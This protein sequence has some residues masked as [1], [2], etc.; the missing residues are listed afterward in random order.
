[1]GMNAKYAAL[2]AVILLIALG[3]RVGAAWWWQQRIGEETEFGFPDSDSYWVLAQTIARGQPYRYGDAD[4]FRTPAYP[5]ALAGLFWAYG[6]QPPVMAARLLGAGLGTLTVGVVACLAGMLFDR[7]AA[8]AAATMA[9]LYP[10]AIAMSTLV[11]SEALFCPLMVTQLLL[12]TAAWRSKSTGRFLVLSAAAGIVAGLAVLT[13]PSWLLFTPFAIVVAMCFGPRRLRQLGLGAVM[14]TTFALAMFPWWLRN[15]IVTGTFVPTTSQV[16][17]SLYDGLNPQ[18][19]GASEMSFVGWQK[20]VLQWRRQQRQVPIDVPLEVQLNRTLARRAIQWA[21]ENPL[22]VVHLAGIKFARTWNIWPNEPSL[23]SW[24]LR[25][26]VLL[27]YVPLLLLGLAGAIQFARRDW[28]LLLCAL[29]AAYVA[30][31]HMVFVGSIRYR[32]PAMLLL[33][34]LAAG[35]VVSLWKRKNEEM[36]ITDS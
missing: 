14:L 19:T 32:Q 5:A 12:W 15:A 17:A 8:L 6:G 33:A 13:R 9:A 25:W 18:A 3:L 27:G 4:V 1:M 11:L 31:L 2:F 21:R 20:E 34:V 10:G 24:P 36:S 35:M 29:P 16:G 22:R 7:R 28:P 26:V 30:L 23:R